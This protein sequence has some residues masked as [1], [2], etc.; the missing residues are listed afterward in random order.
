MSDDIVL[1]IEPAVS[2]N[3]NQTAVTVP[4]YDIS[5]WTD[6]SLT[7]SAE[8]V[9]NTFSATITDKDPGKSTRVPVKPG[10]KCSIYL[11]GDLVLT[12]YVGK[13]GATLDATQHLLTLHGRGCCQD[14][15]DCNAVW[16]GGQ[17]SNCTALSLAQ[18]IAGAYGIGVSTQISFTD[19]IPQF[20]IGF[21]E[22]AF[23]IIERVCR[24]EQ[25]LAYEDATGN[26]VLAHV[27]TTRAASA[28]V[29]GEGGNI[30]AASSLFDMDSRYS[31]YKAQLLS[32]ATMSDAG[33]AGYLIAEIADPGVYRTRIKNIIAETVG[34]VL[35][36]ELAKQRIVWEMNRR[37]GRSHSITVTVDS[38]RDSAG[39]LWQPNTLVDVVC[40]SCHVDTTAAGEA[41]G[42]WIISE[43]TYIRNEG[44]GDVALL[45]MMPP[46]A[47]SPQ[48]ALL[49]SP[50]PDVPVLTPATQK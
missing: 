21:D 4:P 8:D 46:L 43:V 17:V 28:L 29:E 31:L 11:G 9:P 19:I 39:T 13:L 26:L 35:S 33:N 47:F 37:N 42:P 30:Q 6:I 3:I 48:P 36:V 32:M 27:G 20:N 15:V 40:P 2:P 34:G 44:Q 41:Q 23:D 14:L 12:G 45:T 25:C 18:T 10:D 22:L 49:I 5:G 50:F 38:W 16:P 1:H 24:Y 7:R